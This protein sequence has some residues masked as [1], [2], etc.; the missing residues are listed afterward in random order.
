MAKLP[1]R[2][3]LTTPATGDLIHIVDVSDTTSDPT[4][5]SKKITYGNFK[6]NL[7]LVK[8]DVG[9]GN[10]DNT[11]D[12]D[13]PVSTAQQAALDLK[14]D[15]LAEGAFVDGDKTK[16]DGIEAGADVT[17]A[18]NVTAAGALMDSELTNITAI[19]ALD[20]GVST[21]DDVTHNS[22][23]LTSLTASELVG[24]DGSKNLVS[25]PVA[26][27]PSLAEVAYVKGVTSAIQTQLDSKAGSAI[28]YT[29][30]ISDE[31][32]TLTTGTAKVT[33]RTPFACTVSAVRASLNTASTSGTPTF[34]I[35]ENGV[36][37]LST[38]L[39]IDANEKTSTTAATPAV[40]SDSSLADDAEITFDID[41]AGT[42][43]NGAKITLYL[44]EV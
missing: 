37:I 10:V 16:L 12:A 44:I 32:T 18:T 36:S 31:V 5:T 15:I 38:K 24:S 11:S 21:T 2:Q 14:Q 41:V 39:T 4:G 27:Y 35:N 6:D 23:D 25:L 13:K 26:T 34:D 7:G 29:F 1:S 30:A 43:A 22:L 42:G 19:K 33:W 40:I 9:L 3:A 8:S 20:Q 28:P 17:D